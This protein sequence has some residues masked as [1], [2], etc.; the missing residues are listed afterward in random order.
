MHPFIKEIAQYE[1]T[2]EDRYYVTRKHQ[3]KDATQYQ[4][5]NGRIGRRHEGKGGMIRLIMVLA[6]GA[7][8]K[9]LEY[10]PG[11]RWMK[12][13]AVQDIFQ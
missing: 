3:K 11:L 4:Q 8:C 2:R 5:N 10:S 9:S 13:P 12:E 6:V 1:K 7:S